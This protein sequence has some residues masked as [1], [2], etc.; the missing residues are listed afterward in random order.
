MLYGTGDLICKFKELVPTPISRGAVLA[1]DY[2]VFSRFWRDGTSLSRQTEVISLKNA[3]VTFVPPVRVRGLSNTRGPNIHAVLHGAANRTVDNF[4][5]ATDITK[6]ELCVQSHLIAQ[7]CENT[8][9][10]SDWPL[11]FTHH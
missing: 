11:I 6:S 10:S 3:L 1:F 5:L 8:R 4:A 9:P 2:G 7:G